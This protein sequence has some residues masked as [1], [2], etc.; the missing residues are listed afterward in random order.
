MNILALDTS[1][2]YCSVA[3]WRDGALD[4]REVHAGQRHSELVLAM[5]DE[6]LGRHH[7]DVMTLDGIAYGAGPGSFTGLRIAC[8]VTQGLAF[9]ARIPVVGIET[10]L[11]MAERAAADRVVCCI[12]ARMHEIYHAAYERREGAWRVV[13]GPSVVPPHAAPPLPGNAW[14][15]AGNGFAVYREDLMSRYAGCLGGLDA[16]LHP[17]AQEVARLALPAF[18]AGRGVDAALA[19]PLYIRD[20]VALKTHEQR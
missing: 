20:R 3:L 4:A 19:A 11:A 1:S 12:D 9:A 7:M 17:R 6:L 10:S 16:D 15:A 2:E 5:V 18:E 14:F 8:G 13:H